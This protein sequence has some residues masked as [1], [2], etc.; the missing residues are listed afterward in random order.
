MKNK[1]SKIRDQ[2]VIGEFTDF[3]GEKREFVICG[4]SKEIYYETR[5]VVVDALGFHEPVKEKDEF[6]F[7]SV[8]FGIAVRNHGDVF[9]E[10]VGKSIAKSYAM[11]KPFETVWAYNKFTLNYDTISAMLDSF[12]KFFIENPAM[13]I[14]SYAKR[15]AEYDKNPNLWLAKRD[16]QAQKEENIKKAELAL[17]ETKASK[18]SGFTCEGQFPKLLAK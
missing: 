13:F 18:F 15:K 4:I 8:N 5:R 16:F 2:Y 6:A 7:K 3:T 14:P 11:N 10:E 9:S 12:A 1:E 17:K